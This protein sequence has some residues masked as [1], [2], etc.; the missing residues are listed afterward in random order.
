MDRRTLFLRKPF[1]KADLLDEIKI[2]L[3]QDRARE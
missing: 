2:G 3:A 1:R